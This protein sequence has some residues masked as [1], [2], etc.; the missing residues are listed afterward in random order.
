M[1]GGLP[2][3]RRPRRPRRRRRLLLLCILAPR[4]AAVATTCPVGKTDVNGTGQC[5]P[6]APGRF[7]GNRTA[8]G[9]GAVACQTCGPGFYAPATDVGACVPCE[10]GRFFAGPG[11]NDL[12]RCAEGGEG[13]FALNATTGSHADPA[14]CGTCANPVGAVVDRSS[15]LLVAGAAPGDLGTSG[16]NAWRTGP[17]NCSAF[18][19]EVDVRVASGTELAANHFSN[20]GKSRSDADYAKKYCESVGNKN[21]CRTTYVWGVGSDTFTLC[22]W[23]FDADACAPTRTLQAKLPEFTNPPEADPKGDTG[24]CGRCARCKYK[25]YLHEGACLS[26]CPAASGVFPNTNGNT[27]GKQWTCDACSPGCAVCP[28][29]T[30]CSVCNATTSRLAGVNGATATC[31]AQCPAGYYTSVNGSGPGSRRA[32]APFSTAACSPGQG[33]GSVSATGLVN[34]SFPVGATADDG[35]CT[36]CPAGKYSAANDG[37]ACQPMSVADCYVDS[38]GGLSSAS[39]TGLVN[40]SVSVGATADD[41]VCKVCTAG[42]YSGRVAGGVGAAA[43]VVCLPMTTATC[44]PGY[45]FRSASAYNVAGSPMGAAPT[46]TSAS[47]QDDGTCAL[48]PAGRFKNVTDA[49][50]CTRMSHFD[51]NRGQGFRSASAATLTASGSYAGA[52]ADDGACSTCGAG[53]YN[54]HGGQTACSACPV[55]RYRSGTTDPTTCQPMSIAT[56][57]AGFAFSSPSA[58]ASGYSGSTLDDGVCTPCAPGRFNSASGTAAECKTMTTATCGPGYAFRSASANASGF[59]GSTQDDGVCA[60]NVSSVLD[61]PIESEAGALDAAT[62]L[63]E[64]AG[65]AS[66]NGTTTDGGGDDDLLTAQERARQ[67]EKRTEVLEFLANATTNNISL[68]AQASIL[69]AVAAR[70]AALDVGVVNLASTLS[71]NLLSDVLS[72]DDPSDREAAANLSSQVG[73]TVSNLALGVQY[74]SEVD[75]AGED[76]GGAG[77]ASYSEAVG[78]LYDVVALLSQV[79]LLGA[80]AGSPPVVL[81]TP[82]FSVVS[83]RVDFVSATSAPG[84]LLVSAPG[85]DGSFRV[86]AQLGPGFDPSAGPVSIQMT[87]WNV[88]LHDV[89]ARA[90]SRRR[91]ADDDDA[92]LRPYGSISGMQLRQAGASVRVEDAGWFEIAKDW[93]PQETGVR[94]ARIARAAEA[95]PLPQTAA[96]AS[97][98]PTT[99]RYNRT[100]ARC[101]ASNV[102]AVWDVSCNASAV[103]GTATTV[104]Y[105]YRRHAEVGVAAVALSPAASAAVDASAGTA[106]EDLGT[107]PETA[108]SWIAVEVGLSAAAVALALLFLLPAGPHADRSQHYYN[109]WVHFCLVSGTLTVVFHAPVLSTCADPSA[110]LLGLHVALVLATIESGSLMVVNAALLVYLVPKSRMAWGCVSTSAATVVVADDKVGAT[111][112]TVSVT[113]AAGLKRHTSLARKR[114]QLKYIRAIKARAKHKQTVEIF[115]PGAGPVEV[116]TRFWQNVLPLSAMLCVVLIPCFSTTLW[117]LSTDRVLV[118]GSSAERV[119]ERPFLGAQEL[120]AA[121]ARSAPQRPAIDV[122]AARIADSGDSTLRCEDGDRFELVV[123]C[124]VAAGPATADPDACVFW[125]TASTAWSRRGCELVSFTANRTVCR[126]NHLTDFGTALQ[127]SAKVWERVF[128]TPNAT[129]LFVVHWYAILSIGVVLAIFLALGAYGHRYDTLLQRRSEQRGSLVALHVMGGMLARMRERRRRRPHDT[130]DDNDNDNTQAALLQGSLYDAFG[131]DSVGDVFAPTPQHAATAAPAAADA[132]SARP[133]PLSKKSKP[134]RSSVASNYSEVG[135]RHVTTADIDAWGDRERKESSAPLPGIQEEQAQPSESQQLFPRKRLGGARK[136]PRDTTITGE[137]KEQ[138][139]QKDGAELSVRGGAHRDEMAHRF[140]ENGER[141]GQHHRLSVSLWGFSTLPSAVRLRNGESLVEQRQNDRQHK[142]KKTNKHQARK[143][144]SIDEEDALEAAQLQQAGLVMDS[145]SGHY[146]SPSTCELYQARMIHEHDLLQLYFVNDR[147]VTRVH[148][149]V[150]LLARISIKVSVVGTFFVVKESTTGFWDQA[151][152]IALGFLANKILGGIVKALFIL[153][154]SR[155]RTNMLNQYVYRARQAKH[156]ADAAAAMTQHAKRENQRNIIR[157]EIEREHDRDQNWTLTKIEACCCCFC[158]ARC[159]RRM[160]CCAGAVVDCMTLCVWLV[161]LGSICFCLFFGVMFAF[162]LDDPDL[163]ADWLESVIYSICFWVFLSRPG[164]IFLKTLI[165][166]C[167]LERHAA[168]VKRRREERHNRRHQVLDHHRQSLVGAA[169]PGA[170]VVVE[171]VDLFGGG[172][173]SGGGDSGGYER[174]STDVENPDGELVVDLGNDI[175]VL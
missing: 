27:D 143:R 41:G 40:G 76:G 92:P 26:A 47:I 53:Q 103:L 86:P 95:P 99:N 101:N 17:D 14:A 105:F 1:R 133:R 108:V 83:Q 172:S 32:C 19:D 117:M 119:D 161:A 146:A 63:N 163:T 39:A 12:P 98:L 55:A 28:D 130:R 35:A 85:L 142:T 11:D 128:E 43:V 171:M 59:R 150:I 121:R 10:P 149:T 30:T 49:R 164:S 20:Q 131:D 22:R 16:F 158:R 21:K 2:V 48:C 134:V 78:Q 124:P 52:T 5:A 89:E 60:V 65:S 81:S 107:C 93:T 24:C 90:P 61:N 139:S 129:E 154:G 159:C 137:Q 84:G 173:S 123:E 50:G 74:A 4:D 155:R 169:A 114:S 100:A 162:A 57:G 6:C 18:C 111:V 166:K 97:A 112:S 148:R 116:R 62:A 168:V 42:K 104:T 120:A 151:A 145:H 72:S 87:E 157:I 38:G 94:A 80:G 147:W 7:S 13:E 136:L 79:Q 82:A 34:G 25:L 115:H 31:V 102:G 37:A 29:A 106:E 156:G 174:F 167:R 36:A 175:L 96:D 126:C 44:G 77:P 58:T 170:E 132:T 152:A 73:G 69:E 54:A 109:D 8:K 138:E 9:G 140:L 118:A 75:R 110:T 144:M 70:P 3:A 88:N 64:L 125:D 122:L 67:I 66:S 141:R 71:A 45:A 33:F 23:D 46:E 15:G 51:C 56:C 153:L 135:L 160:P 91:L 165:T 127:E 113:A 68:G